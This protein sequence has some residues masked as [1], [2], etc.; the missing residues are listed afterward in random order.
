MVNCN[1]CVYAAAAPVPTSL[2]NPHDI[3]VALA[4]S[5]APLRKS[6]ADINLFALLPPAFAMSFMCAPC[7]SSISYNS[8][9]SESFSGNQHCI[10]LTVAKLL[11]C[12]APVSRQP[13][14]DVQRTMT[15][16]IEAGGNQHCFAPVSRQPLD[17]VQRTMT[18]FIEAGGSNNILQM[19]IRDS[20]I[21]SLPVRSLSALLEL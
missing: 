9:A 8:S 17:D 14:D 7:W 11:V 4:A 10:A 2:N 20:V 13:L 6:L 15:A 18:A 5:L 1:S 12:F 3:D 19:R 21:S 16:F